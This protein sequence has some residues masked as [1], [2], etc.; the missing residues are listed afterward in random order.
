MVLIKVCI[1]YV[2]MFGS[3]CIVPVRG[4]SILVKIKSIAALSIPIKVLILNW[5]P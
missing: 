5:H 2:A 1:I 3:E 4:S